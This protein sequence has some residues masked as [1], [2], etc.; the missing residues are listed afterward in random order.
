M[1]DEMHGRKKIPKTNKKLSIFSFFCF[2]QMNKSAALK[3]AWR[4]RHEETE[5][6]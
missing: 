1:A 6:R 5:K 4:E 2:P 3:Q